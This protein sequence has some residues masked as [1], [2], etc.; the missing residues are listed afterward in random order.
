MDGLKYNK[1]NMHNQI[2]DSDLKMCV[3]FENTRWPL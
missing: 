1:K 3:G 2:L